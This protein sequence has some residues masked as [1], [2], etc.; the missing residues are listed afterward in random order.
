MA[1]IFKRPRGPIDQD[2]RDL[3]F[4]HYSEEYQNCKICSQNLDRL[5]SDD[6]TLNKYQRH[7][8]RHLKKW[9][10]KETKKWI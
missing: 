2:I 6:K 10:R 3:F 9:K 4:F 8:D 5:N 7:F 1:M